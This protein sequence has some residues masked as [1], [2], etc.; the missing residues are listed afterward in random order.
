MNKNDFLSLIG[1]SSPLDRQML[2]EINELIHIFPYFQT[3]HL[4]FLKG[5]QDNSDVK[6]ESQL[7]S[8]A[9]HVADREVLYNLLRVEPRPE[10]LPQPEPAADQE[11]QPAPEPKPEPEVSSVSESHAETPVQPSEEL[12]AEHLHEIQPEES[13]EQLRTEPA[14]EPEPP[15]QLRTETAPE[16]EPPEQLR[17]GP[18]PEPEP[19]EQFGQSQR[20]SLILNP[21]LMLSGRQ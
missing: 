21:E 13:P 5:L 9:I 11:A 19:P 18:A 3:A 10:L 7:R 2:S 1:T 20:L 14:P 12:R 6:F 4:L 8:S 17:T 16:P 15:E